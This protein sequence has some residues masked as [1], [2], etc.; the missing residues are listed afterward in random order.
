MLMRPQEDNN[1]GAIMYDSDHGYVDV[2][3]TPNMMPNYTVG[4]SHVTPHSEGVGHG[5]MEE[6]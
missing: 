6:H 2:S 3:E 4:V 1:Y 5:L